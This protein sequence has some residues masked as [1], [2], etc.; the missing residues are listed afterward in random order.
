[1]RAARQW[2]LADQLRDRLAELGIEIQ[3]TRE[4]PVWEEATPG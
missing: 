3:D 1:L 4:G 2:E